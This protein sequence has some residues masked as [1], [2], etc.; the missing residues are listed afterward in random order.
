MGTQEW[1][2]YCE[3]VFG[4]PVK[5]HTEEFNQIYGGKHPDVTQVVYTN[6]NEDP[7]KRASVLAEDKD[8]QFSVFPIEVNCDN[9]A[10]CLD[11]RAPSPSDCQELTDAR[12]FIGDQLE[13]WIQNE[14]YLMNLSLIHI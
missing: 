1:E 8:D 14:V 13:D 7:W 3:S 2:N 5:P 6:G 10:H 11:L 9:A 4:A 12:T